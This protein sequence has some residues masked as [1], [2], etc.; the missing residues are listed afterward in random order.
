[1][2]CGVTQVACAG[3]PLRTRQQSGYA[4][5]PTIWIPK[6]TRWKPRH[7]VEDPPRVIEGQLD[8]ADLEQM[9]RYIALNRQTILDHWAERTDGIELGRAL[10][11]LP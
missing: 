3:V 8:A 11:R 2:R 9:R 10:R 7:R 4:P 6:L 5:S 1:V